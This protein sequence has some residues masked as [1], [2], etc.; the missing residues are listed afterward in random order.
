MPFGAP[1]HLWLRFL[2]LEI[3]NIEHAQTY[4]TQPSIY[5]ILQA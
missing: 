5:N 1:T 3:V 4:I 2:V